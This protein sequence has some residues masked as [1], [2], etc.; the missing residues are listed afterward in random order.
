MKYY[1]NVSEIP[2]VLLLFGSENFLLEEYYDY[3]ISMLIT[4]EN[5]NYNFDVRNSQNIDM[6]GILNIAN[7]FP[8]MGDK[9]VLVV[10]DFDSLATSKDNKK[11]AKKDD[12]GGNTNNFVKYLENYQKST[13]L[14]LIGAP[15][16]INGVSSYKPNSDKYKKIM[17]SLKTP[18]DYLIKK[19]MF[20]EFT[21]LSH[22]N[23]TSWIKRRFKQ[24]NKS[25]SD[26][27]LEL[28]VIQNNNSL[29][30][31]ANEIDKICTYLA[32]KSRD[33]VTVDDINQI[34]GSSSEVNVFDLQNSVASKR[35]NESIEILGKLQKN[36]KQGILI[37]NI[38][39]K[40]FISLFKM[41]EI[42][43]SN[44]K[45]SN[46]SQVGISPYF[47]DQYV[48]ALKLFG[49]VKIE[50][51]VNMLAEI[52]YKLKS[53]SEDETFLIQKLFIEIMS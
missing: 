7:S 44:D 12:N 38:L 53:T 32:D 34:A 27:A 46:S 24:N 5:D 48:T 8:M 6:D 26:D 21:N 17:N 36:S 18:Y 15:S 4:E 42:D 11:K 19:E 33:N 49:E 10:K 35:L 14:I 20:I 52:D 43:L 25:V 22:S 30:D 51:A 41:L 29:R 50:K 40:F 39:S 31:L 23:L 47:Y 13:Y 16:S 45:Y 1:N 2:N 28:L 3:L 9:R 37:V